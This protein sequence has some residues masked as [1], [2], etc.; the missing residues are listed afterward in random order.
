MLLIGALSAIAIGAMAGQASAGIWTPIASGTVED[1]TALD[2]QGGDR[3]WLATA[4][5]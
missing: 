4:N 3:F 2:Y 5:G 1:I